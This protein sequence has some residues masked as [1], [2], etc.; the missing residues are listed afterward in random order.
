M[1]NHIQTITKLLATH[2]IDAL[3]LT[4]LPHIRWAVGFSGSHALL[5]IDAKG[6]TLITDG[7]YA[8]QA[9]QE[10]HDAEVVIGQLDLLAALS[11]VLGSDRRL[12][13]QADHTTVEEHIRLQQL[14][15]T[16]LV[17]L[18]GLLQAKTL[19][20]SPEELELMRA[21]QSITDTV[22]HELLKIIKPGMT[23]KQVAAEIVYRQLRHGADT[24]SFWPIVAT[25]AHGALP[26]AEASDL[27]LT[28]GDLVVLD[29]GCTVGGYCSDM[30]RTVAIGQP[31]EES[32]K[33]YQLVL[34]AQLA[35]LK[36]ARVGISGV[37]LD[38]AARDVI[39]AG[40][41]DLPHSL[42][43]ALGLEIHEWPSLRWTDKPLPE[44]AVVTIEPGVYLPGKL[45]V[46][47]EDMVVLTPD[48][49]ENLTA[50]PKELIIL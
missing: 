48:G 19:V 18:N 12:G 9:R 4:H 22:F 47:I 25:G 21:A 43:H 30:T 27:K 36:A 5:Y 45:G 1:T 28:N 11:K 17:P 3:L 35:A 14:A 31:D 8:N 29:F 49:V 38:T 24:M 10:V 41:H 34:D 37:E 42:G 26:H 2:D 15:S 39:Q 32:R 6:A 23:E 40:G 33:A 13:F 16:E 50:S 20:K 7:R 44:G 46:R